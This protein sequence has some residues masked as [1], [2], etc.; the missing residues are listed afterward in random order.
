[1]T[2]LTIYGLSTLEYLATNNLLKLNAEMIS[3]HT[4]ISLADATTLVI[5][6]FFYHKTESMLAE[7]KIGHVKIIN[8]IK[9][10]GEKA[11]KAYDVLVQNMRY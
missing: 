1:M 4:G 9:D 2:N 8:S 3:L 6:K 11:I 10:L 5:R 7:E